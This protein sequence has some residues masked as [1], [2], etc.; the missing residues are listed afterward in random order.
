MHVWW[1]EVSLEERSQWGQ[2]C[3]EVT[4]YEVLGCPLAVHVLWAMNELAGLTIFICTDM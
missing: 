1:G 3:G 2:V 4:E